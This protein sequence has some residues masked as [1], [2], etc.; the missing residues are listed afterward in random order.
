MVITRTKGGRV[1]L[2]GLVPNSCYA[3]VWLPTALARKYPS[4]PQEWPWQ[5]VFP[6][7]SL[8]A[9]R[10]RPDAPGHGGGLWRHHLLPENLQRA[11][12]AALR[13]AGLDKRA[14]PHT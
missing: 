5:W 2:I 4:A 10:V 8:T 6:G 1:G 11:M 3:G 12:K 14:T 9:G 7:W 13:R